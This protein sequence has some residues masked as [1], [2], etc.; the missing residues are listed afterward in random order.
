MNWVLED[1][2]LCDASYGIYILVIDIEK[3]IISSCFLYNKH[4]LFEHE[5]VFYLLCCNR[6]RQVLICEPMF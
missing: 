5:I 2:S 6:T 1:R 4:Y 3:M